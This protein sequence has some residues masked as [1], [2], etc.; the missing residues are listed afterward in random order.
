M[1]FSLFYEAYYLQHKPLTILLVK[2]VKSIL[3]TA[4]FHSVFMG[5]RYCFKRL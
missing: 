1:L 3:M 5:D 4:L 2:F